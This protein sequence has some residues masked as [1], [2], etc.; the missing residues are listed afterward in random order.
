MK[1]LVLSIFASLILAVPGLAQR[2][3]PTVVGGATSAGVTATLLTDSDG[4]LHVSGTSSGADKTN[5]TAV[6]GDTNLGTLGCIA[7]AV[8]PTLTPTYQTGNYCDI[9]GSQFSVIRDSQG[10]NYGQTVNAN[11]AAA[12]VGPVITYAALPTLTIGQTVADYSIDSKGGPYVVL[13]AEN[14]AS[15]LFD[16]VAHAGFVTPTPGTTG[17]WS[18]INA[19]AADGATACTNSAQ[20]LKASAGT[21]GGYYTNNPNTGDTW[22]H[23][24]NVAAASVTVGTTAPKLTFRMPGIATNSVAANLEI[25]NG[26]Q[27]DTAMSF[28]CTSTATGNGAPANALESDLFFK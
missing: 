6:P 13:R 24:Y 14:S 19:T 10:N 2:P 1:T 20:V 7:A 8:A 22:L 27:F 25:T 28:A 23:I 9:Y 18:S 17:G 3:T 21:F 11:G 15:A 16:T 12:V 26:I 4:T 5:D